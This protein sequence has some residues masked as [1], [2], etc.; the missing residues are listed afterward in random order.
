[1]TAQAPSMHIPNNGIKSTCRQGPTLETCMQ[2]YKKNKLS[3]L[4]GRVRW[5]KILTGWSTHGEEEEAAKKLW[6]FYSSS[7]NPNTQFLYLWVI[8]VHLQVIETC[9]NTIHKDP[10]FVITQSMRA[11]ITEIVLRKDSADLQLKCLLHFRICLWHRDFA[12]FP[13]SQ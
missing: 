10:D 11:H 1:M 6:Y 8:I 9:K 7:R 13:Q 4:S 2:E 12:Y 3:L 5:L